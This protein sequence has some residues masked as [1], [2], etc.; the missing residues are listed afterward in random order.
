MC[1]PFPRSW[2]R[3]GAMVLCAALFGGASPSW[4]AKGKKPAPG[5][6]NSQLSSALDE[7]G[8]Q[9]QQCAIEHA[10]GKGA[11]KVDISVRVTINNKGTVV[12]SHVNVVAEGGDSGKV[13]EC[14]EA[15]VR[16]AKFPAVNSPLATSERHWIL[17]AQ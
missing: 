5:P 1:N 15:V 11:K 3:L 13:K 16:T 14:V 8:G 7:K 4:G 9:V 10:I 12:D 17:A 2:V 6:K